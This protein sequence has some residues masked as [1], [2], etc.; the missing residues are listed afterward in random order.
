MDDISFA[1]ARDNGAITNHNDIRFVI[2]TPTQRYILSGTNF[3]YTLTSPHHYEVTGG[4][5]TGMRVDSLNGDGTSTME[6][7]IG[8][9]SVS[10]AQMKAFIAGNDVGGFESSTLNGDDILFGSA[11]ND[12]LVGLSGNDE[13]NF[14]TGGSDIG[15]GGKGNDLFSLGAALTA[16]DR[17]DGGSGHDSLHLNGD[18]SAGLT[19]KANTIHNIE[20]ISFNE[21]FSYNLKSDDGN[22]AAGKVLALNAHS[23]HTAEH[24][25]FDGSAE[26][27]GSFNITGGNGQDHLFGGQLADK[28]FAGPQNDFVVGNGGDDY[29]FG[30]IGDD[31]I[32]GGDG[33]DQLLG[34][35][36]DD[37]LTGGAGAD[38]IDVGTDNNVVVYGPASDSTGNAFDTV[39][40]LH[41]ERDH[42]D[43]V[44]A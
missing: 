39:S 43:V 11:G 3:T 1:D 21:G 25:Y 33:A 14:T 18:Y 19:L 31:T 20:T 23:L 10:V 7:S 37:T 40:R 4:T 5:V 16:A 27:D 44:N 22:V 30:G 8:N 41:F 17:L 26:T 28:I 6:Y 34:N 13:F 36:G 12:H 24:F 9:F 29:L 15:E 38:F 32:I 42:I 2:E 35:V